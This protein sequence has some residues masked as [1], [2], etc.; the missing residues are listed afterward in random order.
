[1]LRTKRGQRRSHEGES[2]PTCAERRGRGRTAPH[3]RGQ[4]RSLP[5]PRWYS[6]PVFSASGWPPASDHG[7]TQARRCGPSAVEKLCPGGP[8]GGLKKAF[9]LL[10]PVSL[11][12]WLEVNAL[13]PSTCVF[14]VH[15][16]SQTL[17]LCGSG[18]SQLGPGA[19]PLCAS[20]PTC[21]M[22]TII[23]LTHLAQVSG[24]PCALRYAGSERMS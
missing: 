12:Q 21:R 18:A 4:D 3:T 8:V 9:G 19:W 7:G 17:G 1:M 20:L 11:Q 23:A 24:G 22:G 14:R 16:V 5:L 15:F 10:H 6:G 13:I 2:G